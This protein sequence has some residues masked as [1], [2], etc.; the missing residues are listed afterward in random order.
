MISG[1]LRSDM[2]ALFNQTTQYKFH[3]KN[4]SS[5]IERL[6]RSKWELLEQIAKEC[7]ESEEALSEIAGYIPQYVCEQLEAVAS[8][9]KRE[10]EALDYKMNMV[11]YFVPLMGKMPGLC[12]KDF[13]AKTVEIWNEKMPENKI[14]YSTVESIE[15]GFKGGLCY[16]TTAVCRSLN[17]PDDCYELSLLRNYRD[18]YMMESETGRQIVEEYYN[19][20]P[21]I[22]KK[23]DRNKNSGEIYRQIWNDYL[24]PCVKMIETDQKEACR[25]LYTEMVRKL[26]K[27]YFYS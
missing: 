15:K 14:G 9:R 5:D 3:K 23:I 26:E 8:K 6:I 4:Y 10:I 24:S 13:A 12:A 18:E 7:G 19:I 17:R 11:S 25:N 1:N 22:V 2:I 27:K 20:A 16:I 21:T